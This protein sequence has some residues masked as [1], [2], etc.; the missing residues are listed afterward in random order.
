M[1]DRSRGLHDLD[2]HDDDDDKIIGISDYDLPFGL[3]F[4]FRHSFSS[5]L[6]LHLSYLVHRTLRRYL[7]YFAALIPC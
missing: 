1:F 2:G 6:T 4:F 5:Y 7:P 3:T